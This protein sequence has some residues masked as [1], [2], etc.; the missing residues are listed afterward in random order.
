M[1]TLT[2]FEDEKEKGDGELEYFVENEK[3]LVKYPD[4]DSWYEVF[5]K[6]NYWDYLEHDGYVLGEG[7]YILESWTIVDGMPERRL[8]N[9]FEDPIQ[10]YMEL[11]ARLLA[12][13]FKVDRQKVLDFLG[14]N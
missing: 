6:E 12:G 2:F 5:V 7:K 13:T 4:R 1:A 9:F 8:T 3:L 10:M 11:R 14:V